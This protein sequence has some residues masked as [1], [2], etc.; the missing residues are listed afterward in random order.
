VSKDFFYEKDEALNNILWQSENDLAPVLARV[1]TKMDFD[2]KERFATE[3]P[4][5]ASSST[6]EKRSRAG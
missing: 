6:H 1:T 5:Y 4:C 2:S 3:L